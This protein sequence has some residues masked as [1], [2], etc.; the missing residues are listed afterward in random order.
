MGFNQLK[1]AQ[2]IPSS[3][4]YHTQLYQGNTVQN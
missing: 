4:T 2:I 1:T 3:I